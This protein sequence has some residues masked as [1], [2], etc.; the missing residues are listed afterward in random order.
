[1]ITITVDEVFATPLTTQ[2]QITQAVQEF[3]SVTTF[4]IQSKVDQYNAASGTAFGSV[5]ACECY[6]HDIGYTH[7]PFCA[8]VWAWNIAVWEAV[9]LYQATATTIP[10]DEEFQAVLDGV[11]F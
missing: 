9:R 4:F 1:M 8:R 11:T 6:R 7:Q 5:H 3:T 2:E 10:T